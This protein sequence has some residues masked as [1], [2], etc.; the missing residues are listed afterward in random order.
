M[1]IN[2][3]LI[4]LSPAPIGGYKVVY[5]YANDMAALGHDVTIYHCDQH[6]FQLPE[7]NS[8]RGVRAALIRL[9]R[10]QP[11]Y[12]HALPERGRPSWFDLDPK[13]ESFT[14]S[15]LVVSDIRAADATIGTACTTA[16]FVAALPP[17]VGAKFYFIQHYEDWTAGSDYV[18]ETWRLPLTRVVIARWLQ[19]KG[20]EL[21][22]DTI[23]LPNAI[24]RT[25]FP[26]GP[27]IAE[28]PL[29]VSALLSDTTW[30]RTDLVIEVLEG[31][32]LRIPEIEAHTFGTCPRPSG[33]PEWVD[34]TSS[35][36]PA[37][38]TSIYQRSRVYICAADAEGWHLPLAEAL[39]CGSA[40][41]STDIDGVREY[42]DGI[43]RFSPVGE[44]D[45]LLRNVIDLLD[46]P[47]ACQ[48]AVT[49]FEEYASTHTP[50]H[51]VRSLLDILAR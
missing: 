50:A 24:D 11:R 28:R 3:I 51:A 29:A 6:A 9:L 18:D 26:P 44:A 39:A 10:R 16:P 17:T 15:G 46:D 41:A 31:L 47:A 7:R 42:A 14:S 2:V 25:E 40:A 21:G 27:P 30:K 4:G 8:L 33:L 49:D 1:R 20:N 12:E 43:A 35:P 19:R 36:D 22:V 38:L 32:K 48:T 34:Y 5:R 37:R 13:V 23:H 45:G